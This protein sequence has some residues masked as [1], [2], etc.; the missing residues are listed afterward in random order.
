MRD[1]EQGGMRGRGREQEKR[2]KK[3]EKIRSE[4]HRG[5]FDCSMFQSLIPI[6]FKY[7]V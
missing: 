5:D 1:E 6:V 2:K 4:F 7:P 3:K